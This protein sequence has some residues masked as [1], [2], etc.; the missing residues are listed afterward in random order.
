MKKIRDATFTKRLLEY[1]MTDHSL[2][3]IMQT[4]NIGRTTLYACMTPLRQLLK[5][6]EPNPGERPKRFINAEAY[7]ERN[8]IL[9][10]KVEKLTLEVQRLNQVVENHRFKEDKVKQL[11][12]YMDAKIK[13]FLEEIS[14]VEEIPVVSG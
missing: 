14:S 2:K 5:I 11:H 10:L 1:L 8:S 3:E 7:Y 13:R 4:F 12:A 6:I 9:T